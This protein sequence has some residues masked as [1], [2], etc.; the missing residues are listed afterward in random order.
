MNSK[1]NLLK[2]INFVVSV[3]LLLFFVF[4]FFYLIISPSIHFFPNVKPEL[5]G[6]WARNWLG[7]EGVELQ[8]M[9]FATIFYLLAA[10]LIFKIRQKLSFINSFPYLFVVLTLCYFFFILLKSD[11]YIFPRSENIWNYFLMLTIIPCFLFFSWKFYTSIKNTLL[12]RIIFLG[13]WLSLFLIIILSMDAPS[14]FDYGYLIGPALKIKQGVPFKEF[15]MQYGLLFT[16]IFR[17]I[18]WLKM[19]VS[20]MQIFLAIS[21]FLWIVFYYILSSKLIKDKTLL[22]LFLVFLFLTRFFAL[23]I[24][25]VSIPQALP[26]RSD[27]WVISA[28][29]ILRFGFISW[30]TSVLFS[31]LFILDSTYGLFYLLDYIAFSTVFIWF[32]KSSITIKKLLPVFTPIVLGLATQFIFFGSLFSSSIKEYTKLNLGFMPISNHSLF[33]IV[34]AMLP[35][36]AFFSDENG[37]IK[38]NLNRYFLLSIIPIQLVYFF[39]RSHDHN[40]LNNSGIILLWTFLSFEKLIELGIKR[41]TVIFTAGVVITLM[42]VLSTNHTLKK[43]NRL[44]NHVK[45]GNIFEVSSVEKTAIMLKNDK[46]FIKEIGPGNKTVVI[47][48]FDS[49]YNYY[50]GLQ[51][52]GY[53]T[54]FQTSAYLE[55]TANFITNLL[56]NNYKLV[57]FEDW[58]ARV[59]EEVNIFN[60]TQN[61]NKYIEFVDRG[62]YYEL[63]LH[64]IENQKS[65]SIWNSSKIDDVFFMQYPYTWKMFVS[66]Q[67]NKVVMQDTEKSIKVEF[68]IAT[69]PENKDKSVYF[70]EQTEIPSKITQQGTFNIPGSDLSLVRMYEKDN[71]KKL[72]MFIFKNNVVIKILYWPTDYQL[73]RF[74]PIISTI[75]FAD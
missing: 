4:Y 75:K 65:I 31:L 5:I 11:L 12:K 53:F 66:E 63:N 56:E 25:P 8:V 57:V 67:T 61:K 3:S 26:I 51:Q 22:Y 21:F 1:G 28:L 60:Y 44:V 47:S 36:F 9:F 23:N 43:L 18:I 72:Q 30:K 17:F 50:F 29:M 37:N 74:I 70:M 52:L 46:E 20:D 54:P 27:L 19:K 14:L 69:I 6:W 32:N 64:K 24:D 59:I 45:T 55:T 35:F 41:K 40:L 38:K 68:D 10:F 39:G 62:N 34:A 58:A 48:T 73:D 33:W 7:K 49:F 71:I 16:M 15:F 2:K 13:F 42:G